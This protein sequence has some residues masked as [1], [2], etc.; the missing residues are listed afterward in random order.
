METTLYELSFNF[1]GFIGVLFPLLVSIALFF[2]NEI[3]GDRKGSKSDAQT[4]DNEIV[5]ECK[6]SNSD[7]KIGTKEMSP[8]AFKIFTRVIGGFLAACSLL[9][10]VSYIIEYREYK[11]RLD[12]NDIFVAE[13]Y[14]TNFQEFSATEKM[15]ES[16]EIDGVYF[17]Y[18]K[19]DKTN[20]YHNIAEKGGV[21]THD[22]QYLKIK[23]V[24][25][26]KE[27]NIILAI[28]EKE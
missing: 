5:D 8:K 9:F 16:F 7:T 11:T 12:N 19:Q 14:V 20:G 27:G 17:E 2:A 13:G 4:D 3:L 18:S 26:G 15:P 21:I 1:A 6:G 23:Y 22:G 24:T 10:V 28:Y 25:N